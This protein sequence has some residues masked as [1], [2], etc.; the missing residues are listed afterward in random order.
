MP[1]LK[2]SLQVFL[3]LLSLAVAIALLRPE[4]DA[5]R[6]TATPLE[7]PPN[8][9]A[10]ERPALSQG[11]ASAPAADTVT[12]SKR[13]NEWDQAFAQAFDK[14]I[15]VIAHKAAVTGKV[16]DIVAAKQMAQRCLGASPYWHIL[17]QEP[18][19]L[20]NNLGAHRIKAIQAF[21]QNCEG[22][23]SVRT[24][25]F[26]VRDDTVPPEIAGRLIGLISHPESHA[27]VD[28]AGRQSLLE[29]VRATG[30]TEL[31]RSVRGT[32]LQDPEALAS[33]GLPPDPRFDQAKDATMLHYALE[34][35]ACQRSGRCAQEALLDM[36][37]LFPQ[38]PWG[39]CVES[40]A[41][42][43]AV[44]MFG[45]IEERALWAQPRPAGLMDEALLALAA[46]DPSIERTI[47]PWT[48]ALSDDDLKERWR[49][50]QALA[51]RL[52]GGDSTMQRTNGRPLP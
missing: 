7:P 30:S 4:Q 28:P 14:P 2:R 1:K 10:A 8:W 20:V 33:L 36:Q 16:A 6:S 46:K 9:S 40:L 17:R 47:K 42:Y 11:S 19:R 32:L 24:Q 29:F 3:I 52:G 25:T 18:G 41:D 51:S 22:Y 34:L 27:T 5:E 49:Q 50:M 31:P 48:K 37:C 43:P 15:R 38:S 26:S 44:R 13:F 12:A 39:G 35:Q 23:Q 45:S 21:E